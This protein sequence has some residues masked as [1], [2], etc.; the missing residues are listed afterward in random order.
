[1]IKCQVVMNA[2]DKAAPRH[3]AESWD[4]IG[5]MVGSPAQ[6]VEKIFV[7]LDI[8][9]ETVGQ[10]IAKGCDMMVSH[11]PLFFKPLKNIRTDL[12][13][14]KL[15]QKIIQ[16]DM[17]VFSAHT[18]LD[19]AAGGVNDVLAARIGLQNTKDFVVTQEE[20]LLK[21]VVF[22]PKAQAE[23]VKR[24]LGR[25][26]A[27]QIGQYEDCM[28]SVPGTGQFL[29]M[30]GSQPFCGTKGKMEIVEEIRIET[31]FPAA[32]QRQI[33]REL[34]AVHPYEEPAYDLY[35]LKN[36]GEIFSLGRIGELPEVLTVE[37]FAESV[38]KALPSKSLRYVSAGA[39]RIKRVALCSGSGAEFISKA[40]FMGADVYVTGDVRYH[41]AQ[42]AR[43]SGMH[44]ID[45]GHFGT[46]M[47]VVNVLAAYLQKESQA[48][49]WNV[50]VYADTCSEDI[51]QSL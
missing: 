17:S 40:A 48:G 47:P 41:E 45:A 7:C 2:L 19:I 26:G 39:R 30:E 38:K 5:L 49:G 3:L 34:L 51:F 15:L 33:V 22:V 43:E 46:E 10:A 35:P 16:A 4:T 50:E 29:P 37:A 32:R 44:L 8:S 9:E 14:G 27:G 28:F 1:M 13:Q 25:A 11:H 20:A 36:T 18:N 42:K 23:L 21:L 12:P 6:T 31:V 24:A